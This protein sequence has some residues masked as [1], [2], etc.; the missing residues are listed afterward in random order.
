MNIHLRFKK[1]YQLF[2]RIL[3]ILIL[4]VIVRTRF[5]TVTTGTN[6][7]AR[8]NFGF[9]VGAATHYAA[10]DFS[11]YLYDFRVTNRVARENIS[12]NV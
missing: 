6:T 11:G 10:W 3:G 8:N 7:P 4:S 12:S 1:C 2:L 9:W 5:G